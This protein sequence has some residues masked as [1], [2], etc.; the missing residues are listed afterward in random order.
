MKAL[1]AILACAF[2]IG[3]GSLAFSKLPRDQVIASFGTPLAGRS[4]SQR[5]NSLLAL[6]RLKGVVIKGGAEF[7]FNRRV[8][9]FS[10]DAGYRRAPVSYNGQLISDW[11]GG[12]CQTSTTLY[13][14]ALLAGMKILER[15]RHRFAPGYVQPGR[16]A[17]V[18]Y[19]NID[20]RFRNPYPFPVRIDGTIEGDILVVSLVGRQ[21]LA[22]RPQ[23][24][25]EIRQTQDYQTFRFGKQ[26]GEAKV[27]NSGKEGCEVAVYRVTGEQRELVSLDSYPAMNRVVQYR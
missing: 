6:S 4:H 27:R 12:V 19:T 15:H 3:M 26:T 5:H 20:L 10:Q 11:G 17:A 24:V 23:I 1:L 21:P 22:Q 16:D 18:A 2:A 9:T 25:S 7:S 14:A 13:N 8:G